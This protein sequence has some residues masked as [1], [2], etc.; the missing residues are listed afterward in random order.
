MQGKSNGLP[1]WKF[2]TIIRADMLTRRYMRS[3]SGAI[4]G[5][6]GVTQREAGVAARLSGTESGRS[7]DQLVPWACW[8]QN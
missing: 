8:V 6:A 1:I 5:E 7:C 2:L 3:K 4:R